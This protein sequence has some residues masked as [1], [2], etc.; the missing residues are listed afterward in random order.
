MSDH[1]SSKQQ[2]SLHNAER[3]LANLSFIVARSAEAYPD[4]LAVVDHLNEQQVTYAELEA[5]INRTAWA[6]RNAGVGQGDL[7]AL[8]FYNELPII[9]L[10]MAVGRLGAI[11]CPINVRLTAGEVE[12][13]LRPHGIKAIVVNAAMADRF[14]NHPAAIRIAWRA[15]HAQPLPTGWL[16]LDGLR[17]QASQDTPRATTSLDSAFR[18]IPT[19][20]TTGA[21][22]GVLHS[23][24]GTLFT[25]LANVADFGIQRG[26][27]TVLIAPTYHGAGM[28]WALFPVLWRS[29][30]V[31][32]PASVSFSAA[33]YLQRVR[34]YQ[35]EY[36]LVVPAVVPALYAAWDG[37]PLESV[38]SV[39]TTSAPTPLP[40]RQKLA[41]L[42]P[43]AALR[44]GSGISESLNMA[45]QSPQQ[46]LT[47]PAS[48][49]EPMLDTR[50]RIVDAQG[51]RVAPGTIGEICLRGFN[52]ALGYH[53]NDDAGSQTW[54]PL[55]DDTEGLL[56]CF[57]G[58]LGV[59]DAAGDVRIVDRS[60]DVILTGGE[61]VPSVEIEQVYAAHEAVREVAAIGLPDERWGEAI[62][63]VVVR[64]GAADEAELAS[65]LFAHGRQ[66]LAGFKV[67][68]RIV[69]LDALPRS[70]FGKVLKRE[71]RDLSFARTYV[72]EASGM[73][74]KTGDI[75]RPGVTAGERT[76]TAASGGAS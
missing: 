33:E 31:V 57:T 62:T 6:L 22:K 10:L 17:G 44:G 46:F 73:H 41:A 23:H 8:L 50:L 48:V 68:K 71:L 9:E 58:D 39:I 3:Q 34:Q 30:T 16:D 74:G 40:L 66:H 76:Q 5:R 65:R 38:R 24:G 18:M 15:D 53:R 61:T 70:H 25:V 26:W 52:T 63:L 37:K 20:G 19:G 7:V 4:R 56:W 1:F 75:N 13:Y 49:G 67:P 43:R 54:R 29:G 47:H 11:A 14:E 59:Q 35:A 21:S 55:A 36:L 69:Y 51:R 45:V 60:K 64:A 72:P 32:L 28:D 2:D 27:K 42:F 12:A